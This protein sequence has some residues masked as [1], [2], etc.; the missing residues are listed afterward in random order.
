VT[1]SDPTHLL[2]NLKVTLTVDAISAVITDADSG[3]NATIDGATI[4]LDLDLE[5]NVGNTFTALLE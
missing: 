5:G 4:T 1:V 2:K 3:I